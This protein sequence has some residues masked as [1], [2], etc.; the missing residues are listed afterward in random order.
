MRYHPI[1]N[2]LS[3]S[4]SGSAKTTPQSQYIWKGGKGWL[5][6]SFGLSSS[7]QA[8]FR[9]EFVPLFPI[10]AGQGA[11]HDMLFN[12]SGAY[13]IDLPPGILTAYVSLEDGAS[14]SGFNAWIVEP[15]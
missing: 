7:P 12:T 4:A 15:L 11:Q 6:V 5:T 10:S 9:L 13:V 1:I 3:D 8:T 2:N 14:V